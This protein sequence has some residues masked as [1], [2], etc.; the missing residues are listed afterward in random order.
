VGILRRISRLIGAKTIM[1]DVKRGQTA[2]G[3]SLKGLDGKSY[4][5]D[6]LRQKGA[7]LAA[8]FKISC[9]VCQFTF[10]FLERL[11]QRY[12]GDNVTFL[13]ISQDDAIA[14]AGF[15]RQYGV[16]FPLVL[17]EKGNG[18]PASN[19]Y[20]LTSVPTIFLID[21]DGTVRINSM[22][23]VKNDLERIAA[24]LAERRQVAL[25]PLFRPNESVPANKPG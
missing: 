12:G 16:T 18:Y 1:T 20:G 8:F 22:G 25:S 6:S 3:F 19:A 15:T 10:P 2:P 21:E 4:S 14:T 13:G 7:V 23:F 9:P 24:E 17:D 5:L 11:Y